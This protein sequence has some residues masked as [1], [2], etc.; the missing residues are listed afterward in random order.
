MTAARA[1]LAAIAVLAAA[2]GG[3]NRKAEPK[4]PAG[5]PG[6]LSFERSTPDAKVKLTLEPQIGKHPGLRQKLYDDGVKELTSFV[7]QAQNDRAH[8][9]AKGLPIPAYE[10]QISW[11]ITADTPHLLSAHESWF[12]Y[13]GGAHP[14]HGS[15]A[16]LWDVE[17]DTPIPRSEMFLPSADQAKL[18][19]ALCAAIRAAKAQRPGS[20]AISQDAGAWSCPKWSDSNFVFAPSTAPG[21]IGGLV[22]L[23][24]PYV[25]GPYVEGDYQV[26]VPQSVFRD[27]LAPAWA[28]D[29]AGEPAPKPAPPPHR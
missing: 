9:A 26:S 3:C 12:D 24:D 25:L 6:P 5:P 8:V 14:N 28:D 7:A 11:T 20:A 2:L 22:F 21:K 1:A 10:R 16:L 27:A 29:F 15:I 17:R 4:P 23:Y 18:D 19:T 13:T